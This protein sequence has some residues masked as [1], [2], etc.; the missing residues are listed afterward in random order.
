M[1][2]EQQGTIFAEEGRLPPFPIETLG[3][4][5]LFFRITVHP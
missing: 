3:L 2:R 5:H 4:K 1:N